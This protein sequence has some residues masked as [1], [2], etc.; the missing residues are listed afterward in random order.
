[1][2]LQNQVQNSEV[3][4]GMSTSNMYCMS[5]KSVW[6]STMASQIEKPMQ[7]ASKYFEVGGHPR[8][9]SLASDVQRSG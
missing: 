9:V 8:D 3:H 6:A 2:I 4:R 1:M 7:I 5:G